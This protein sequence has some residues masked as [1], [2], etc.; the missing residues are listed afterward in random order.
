MLRV[1]DRETHAPL[2]P[3]Q[4]HACEMEREGVA[5]RERG[6]SEG[7]SE[8]EGRAAAPTYEHDAGTLL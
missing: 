7:E 1:P 3:A 2:S 4:L 6:E 5:A 8:R